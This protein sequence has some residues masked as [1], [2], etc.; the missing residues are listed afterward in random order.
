MPLF[1][2]GLELNDVCCKDLEEVEAIVC[3]GLSKDDCGFLAWYKAN[4]PDGLLVA[5][6]LEKLNYLAKEDYFVQ[7]DLQK[8]VPQLPRNLLRFD[9]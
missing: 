2:Y 1:I 4:N 8:I 6:D 7:G 3:I 9:I 5:I